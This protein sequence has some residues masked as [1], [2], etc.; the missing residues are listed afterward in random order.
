MT[1]EIAVL[2]KFG[3]ALA[4]DS[5]ITVETLHDN[6]LK[7]KV[8]NS[9]NKLFTLSKF[10]PIGIMFYNTVTL[11]G[12]P[13]E[14][15]I[16][17]YRRQLSDNRFATVEQYAD[18]FF[19]YVASNKNLFPD[20][21]LGAIFFRNVARRFISIIH[22]GKTKADFVKNI[23]AEIGALEKVPDID[24]FTDNVTKACCQKYKV[25]T[26]KALSILPVSY[27]Q[28]NRKK[29]DKFVNL[30]IRKKRKLEGFSGIVIT[31]F[32]EDEYLPRLE[33]YII[34]LHLGDRVRYWKKNK[35]AIEHT[36]ASEIVPFAD[37]EVIRT[38][39]DGL[40]PNFE[41]QATMSA[42]KLILEI[43][44]RVLDGVAE[45]DGPTRKKYL[46]AARQALPQQ[47]KAY[48]D[49]MLEFRTKNYTT[50]IKNAISSLPISELG[51]VAEALLNSSQILKKVNPDIE[52][53]GGPVDVA[54][55]SKGDGFVWIK[56]KHYFDAALNHSFSHR[57]LEKL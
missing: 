53:V 50:P 54:V 39:I 9:A 25:D 2:N 22:K 45:L 11:G 55:I 13:W 15:I 57:Y 47:F 42:L 7:T 49:E 30:L 38:L 28:G 8:H 33:E 46:D 26:E 12:V 37:T 18:D 35:I 34:D 14:T 3:I 56:R 17:S 40:S 19:L 10:A 52:T 20:V 36:S 24:G 1:A 27:I 32:G 31:G 44:Q 23:D 29:I 51:A 43:P 5:A 6:E 21:A 4:S 41:T 16:K 48:R